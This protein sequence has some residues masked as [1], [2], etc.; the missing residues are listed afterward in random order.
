MAVLNSDQRRL[1]ETTVLKAREEAERAVTAALK[2]LAVDQAEAFSTMADAARRLRVLLRAEARRLGDPLEKNRE[3]PYPLLVAEGAYEQWHRMLFARFLAENGLLRHPEGMPVTLEDCAE[4]APEEGAADGPE[5][6]ARYAAAMLPGIFRNEDPLLQL[7]LVIESRL[8]LQR[9]LAGL[10]AAAFQAEDALGWVY[11][12]WQARRKKEVNESGRKIGGADIAPVTQLFTEPYMVQFLLHNT[13]GAWWVGRHPAEPLPVEMEYLRRLD[14][15]SPAA[16]TFDGWPDQAAD[17]K[18]LDPCCG[19]GHFLVTAFDLLCRFRMAE[20]GLDGAAAGDAVL[21]DNLFGLEIDPRCTQ[22]AAFNLALAAWKAGGG[23]RCLPVPN[24]ACSGLPVGDRLY[25][26]TQLANGDPDLE[27]SLRRLYTL[28]RSAPDLGSLID[29]ARAAATDGLFAPVWSEVNPLLEKALAKEMGR[30]DPAAA[31]FGAAAQ[32]A[33]RAVVMLSGSYHLVSTNVPYLLRRKQGEGLATHLAARHPAA[34]TDLATAF[35]ERCAGFCLEGGVCALVTPQNW[36][37]LSSYC[38]LR[39][40]LLVSQ[41]WNIFAVLGP[42]AFETISGHVVNPAL[43]IA[44]VAAPAPR[45][46]FVTIDVSSQPSPS[47]KEALLRS[48]A[49]RVT[50]Q[51]DQLRNPDA[52]VVL[53]ENS[54]GTELFSEFAA[55][56]LGF[57]SGDYPRFGRCFWELPSVASGWRLQQGTV[58]QTKEYGG[59]E[60]V[61]LW[62]TQ[63]GALST[64]ATLS[65]R[66]LPAWGKR[67]VLVSLLGDLRTTLYTGEMFDVATAVLLPRD[68]GYLPAMWAF[69]SSGEFAAAVRCIDQKMNVTNGTLVKVPFDLERWQKVAAELYPDGLPPPFSGEP[70]QWLFD[71]HP[72]RSTDHLQVA[73]ARL[74]GYQ[75]P[76]QTGVQVPGCDPQPEDGLETFADPDGI[77]CLPAVSGE[78]PA[79]QRLRA[80]LAAAYGQRWG[81][82]VQEK[83]L[84][85]AG[86]SG[87]R[88]GEWLRDGFFAQHCRLFHNRP[89]IWHIWDGRKDGFSALVN[90]HRLDRARLEKLAYRYLGDWIRTQREA[91]TRGEAGANA[92]LTAALALQEALKAILQGEPPY[93]IYVR[94]KPL[95]QQPIGWEP[96]L[97]DGVRLNIRPFCTA[98]ILRAR[99]TIHWK[100]DRGLNPDGSERI[101]D[102]H[103]ARAEREAARRTPSA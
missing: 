4:L 78:A 79:E 94:W 27:A 82:G 96:D 44:T 45:H 83:L 1:L 81:A 66:G 70:T 67:G 73:V 88:L 101:N 74:L 100:K 61:I 64:S 68:E 77:V 65:L 32:G 58:N 86:F 69:S 99:F 23:Y 80:L 76:R 50:T 21:R 26:W 55:S 52:R 47:E 49:L 72:A 35:V 42:G 16:G 13:L 17:L 14:D 48:G 36:R 39:R 22:L 89:F 85:V 9:L 103:P 19:S 2:T 57:G 71:G 5:L 29:P 97:N 7:R 30:D 63:V 84:A 28:F 37:F 6:A 98:G 60:H 15:G 54:D 95:A 12:F 102:L 24:V 40:A 25:Q 20:E 11:Q 34:K 31:V 33:L 18:V 92:R 53:Q 75:W 8:A 10:P 62:D 3:N 91:D 56:L 59:R 46:W 90:Y 93:D 43:L 87:R 41:S 38:D 51:A